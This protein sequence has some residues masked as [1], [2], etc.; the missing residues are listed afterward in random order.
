MNGNNKSFLR[1]YIK[2]LNIQQV[3]RSPLM[4][5]WWV[6]SHVFADGPIPCLIVLG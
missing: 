3:V 4:G 5:V 1:I 6:V 2:K